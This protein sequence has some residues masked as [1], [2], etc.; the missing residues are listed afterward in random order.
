MHVVSV[1][2]RR[3]SILT[4]RTDRPVAAAEI[5]VRYW[6]LYMVALSEEVGAATSWQKEV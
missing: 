5:L 2:H 4:W 1:M 6:F 3:L